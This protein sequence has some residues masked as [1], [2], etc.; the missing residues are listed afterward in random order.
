[1]Q[2]HLITIDLDGTT[3]NSQSELSEF[4][5]Q[6][7]QKLHRMGHLVSIVTGRPYRNSKQFYQQLGIKTPIVNFNGA[8]CHFPSRPNW[9]P[10]Y[11]E[12]VDKEVA[13]AIFEHIQDCDVDL[14]CAEGESEL[15]TSSLDLPDS[16]YYPFQPESTFLLSKH[17][18]QLNPTA[19]TIFSSQARQSSIEN[20][21]LNKYSDFVSVRT[22]G[23]PMP[24]LEVVRKGIHKAIGVEAIANFYRIP[25]EAILAF[26]DE[27][28][29]LEML[30]YAGHG[31]AMHNAVSELKHIANDVTEFS[32]DEDGLAHYLTDYFKL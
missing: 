1:M 25:R 7:L 8:L 6:T 31:V 18:M 27:A 19:L 11:H 28:N 29:D 2:Q 32:N 20:H 26:G 3:L 30:D 14:Y 21:I 16:P 9:I 13:F 5:I 15:F 12:A 23:G 4:T 24:C 10:A 22:W 17:S